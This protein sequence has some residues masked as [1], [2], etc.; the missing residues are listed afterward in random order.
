MTD[1][2]EAPDFG[3]YHGTIWKTRESFQPGHV[4]AG[5][6]L[7]RDSILGQYYRRCYFDSRS[8][9]NL[10]KGQCSQDSGAERS[11]VWT[12]TAAGCIVPRDFLPHQTAF[13]VSPNE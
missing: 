3:A 4:Q 2:L 1:Y 8:S 11:L 7:Q 6:S 5:A 12:G 10:R 9:F 13:G